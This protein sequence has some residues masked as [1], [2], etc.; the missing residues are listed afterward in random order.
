MNIKSFKTIL[1]VAIAVLLI[2][3]TAFCADPVS[4]VPG[5]VIK[6]AA[7][8]IVMP[9][10]NKIAK[11]K[12][13]RVRIRSMALRA[14]IEEYSPDLTATIEKVFETVK[15]GNQPEEQVEVKDTY[16]V[17]I[18]GMTAGELEDFRLGCIAIDVVNSAYLD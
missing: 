11:A 10:G 17:R 2:H 6:V 5:V 14:V 15:E 1:A 4:E 8:R 16:I 12:I 3:A 18:P 7:N 13:K 9:A